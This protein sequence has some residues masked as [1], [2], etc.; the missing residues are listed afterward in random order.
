LRYYWL[1]HLHLG[2][3]QYELVLLLLG[4]GFDHAQHFATTARGMLVNLDHRT[5]SGA[6]GACPCRRSWK[7]HFEFRLLK[8]SAVCLS[9]VL[10]TSIWFRIVIGSCPPV[11]GR[12]QC[13]VF[14]FKTAN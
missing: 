12:V 11:E 3:G 10:R 8:Q 6:G 5:A 1:R 4:K 2:F 7:S 14:F 9:V 13:G